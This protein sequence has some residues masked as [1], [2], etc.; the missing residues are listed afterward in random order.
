MNIVYPKA[1]TAV[2]WC[3]MP[4]KFGSNM[5]LQLNLKRNVGSTIPSHL[6]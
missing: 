2:E 1:V 3:K 5:S 4:V 6:N